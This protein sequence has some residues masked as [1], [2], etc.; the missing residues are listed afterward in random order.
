MARSEVRT[1]VVRRWMTILLLLTATIVI[2]AVTISLSGRVYQKI[3]PV[4]FHELRILSHRL[5]R[6]PVPI[7]VVIALLMPMILNMLIF[8]PWGMLMFL[9]LDTDDRPTNQSYVITFILGLGFSS[10]VEAYQYFLPTRVTDVND[11]I[12]NGVGA[13][14]GAFLGHLRKRVRVTFE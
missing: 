10:C 3:D 8:V 9:S 7:S 14:L 1:V 5:A 6:G 13:L 11:V 2:A 4:P 12:W